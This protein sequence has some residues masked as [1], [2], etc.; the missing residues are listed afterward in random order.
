M[1]HKEDGCFDEHTSFLRAYALREYPHRWLC[2]LPV[3][4]VHSLENLCDL[5]EDTFYHFNPE[6]L[7]QK[8]LQQRKARRESPMDFW[9]RFRDLQ[10]QAPK[11]QMKF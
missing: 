2:I 3:E 8:L 10:F 11:S 5:I 9:R 7:D 6:H 4:N 1:L